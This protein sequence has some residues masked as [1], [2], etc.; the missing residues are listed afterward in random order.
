MVCGCSKTKNTQFIFYFSPVKVAGSN[1]LGFQNGTHNLAKFKYLWGITIN[2]NDNRLYISDNNNHC[3]RTV[4]NEGM[5]NI[6]RRSVLTCL[7]SEVLTF[8]GKQESKGMQNSQGINAQ[9]NYPNQLAFSSKENSFLVAD[10]ANNLIRKI[11][12]EGK[13]SLQQ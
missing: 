8:V 10:A 4:N 12:M 2:P 5:V 3:I 9:F 13:S 11:T 6:C 7:N 1:A